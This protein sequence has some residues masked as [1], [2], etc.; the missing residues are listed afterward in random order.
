MVY[1]G[2]MVRIAS[3]PGMWD[4]WP[5]GRMWGEGHQ[6]GVHWVGREDLLGDGLEAG[7]GVRTRPPH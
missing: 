1:E 7:L 5:A 4:R 6:D 2:E 3:L